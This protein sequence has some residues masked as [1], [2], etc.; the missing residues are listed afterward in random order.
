V[1]DTAADAICFRCS[2]W[3]QPLPSTVV[4]QE[5]ESTLEASALTVYRELGF[6][7]G[8]QAK[9]LAGKK[10]D[11][12]VREW[13]RAQ[14]LQWT[15]EAAPSYLHEKN[16]YSTFS[17][18][19][20]KYENG[21][22]TNVVGIEFAPDTGRVSKLLMGFPGERSKDVHLG[23]QLV[24][25]DG[26]WLPPP[27]H[28]RF[29]EMLDHL[30]KDYLGGSLRA[31]VPN[32]YK[33]HLVF[34]RLVKE[35]ELEPARTVMTN[36]FQFDASRIAEES[37][38]YLMKDKD[39]NDAGIALA[40][41]AGA[42]E[43]AAESRGPNDRG[44]VHLAEPPGVKAEN[45]DAIKEEAAAN[46]PTE[47]YDSIEISPTSPATEEVKAVALAAREQREQTAASSSTAPVL[48]SGAESTVMGTAAI[49]E[50]ISLGAKEELKEDTNFEPDEGK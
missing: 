43:M 22:K 47:E 39:G 24:S 32:G 41:R 15:I 7:Q 11:K 18:Q 33:V 6:C 13:C 40:D 21:S 16:G 5:G 14:H 45:A 50:A 25:V 3:F 31:D 37:G 1:F 48:D 8:C 42:E 17:H 10:T 34:S 2:T 30:K 12:L 29:R 46:T 38:A 28:P 19:V 20:Q 23:D 44:G 49:A 9:H 4:V 36:A 35:S 26:W 27:K